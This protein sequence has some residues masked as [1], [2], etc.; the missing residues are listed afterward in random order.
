[1]AGA[2]TYRC[3]RKLA[4]QSQRICGIN[5]RKV[6]IGEY[7]YVS[8]LPSAGFEVPV[9]LDRSFGIASCAPALILP[10]TEHISFAMDWPPSYCVR[11]PRSVRSAS[12]WVTV[13]QAAG[14]YDRFGHR[15][16]RVLVHLSLPKPVKRAIL[17]QTAGH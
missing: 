9:A 8:K 3:Q 11:A 4:K 10:P 12:C 6:P 5:G 13:E 1:V 2:V 14:Y 16:A 7:F 17:A 15:E